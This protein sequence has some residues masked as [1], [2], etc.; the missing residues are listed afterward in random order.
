MKKKQIRLIN[1]FKILNKKPPVWDAVCETFNIQPTQIL[2]TYGHTIYNPDAVAIPIH[3]IEHEK[4]HMRQ[5]SSIGM[6]P[7]LWWEK[8]LSDPVFRV[9]QEAEAYGIQYAYIVKSI[10]DRN[11]KF[12]VLQDLARILSGPLYN[13]SISQGEA[14]KKIK[15]YSGLK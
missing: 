10:K 13:N 2:F 3:I 4:V 8:F 14:M 9:E 5:Q 7:E 15:E 11:H 6:T 12:R 1:E